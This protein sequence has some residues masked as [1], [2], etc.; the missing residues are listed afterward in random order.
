MPQEQVTCVTDLMPALAVWLTNVAVFIPAIYN[1]T[2]AHL[3]R[4]SLSLLLLLLLL[5]PLFVFAALALAYLT[6]LPY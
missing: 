5:L 3:V 6:F 2:G 1:Q 4:S